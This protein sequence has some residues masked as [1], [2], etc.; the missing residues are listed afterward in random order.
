MVLVAVGGLKDDFGILVT[1]LSK[2]EGRDDDHDDDDDDD[3]EDEDEDEYEDDD[4]RDFRMLQA[5][6]VSFALA[7]TRNLPQGF[8]SKGLEIEAVSEHNPSSK[9]LHKAPLYPLCCTTQDCD[10]SSEISP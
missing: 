7:R 8:S 6:L 4:T 10:S 2:E 5:Q 1:A 3:D 9:S